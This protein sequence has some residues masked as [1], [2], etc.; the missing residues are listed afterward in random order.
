MTLRFPPAWVVKMIIVEKRLDKP[1]Y[2]IEAR[3][4]GNYFG[5]IK[6][7][8]AYLKNLNVG[9]DGKEVRVG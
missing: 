5:S 9:V 2:C 6:D 4:S 1:R 7:A 3:P 8:N